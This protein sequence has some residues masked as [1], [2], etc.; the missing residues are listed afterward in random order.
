MSAL[1][2]AA[3]ALV[4]GIVPWYELLP[5]LASVL[6]VVGLAYSYLASLSS[7]ALGER[8]RLA[9]AKHL[10]CGRD[11]RTPQWGEFGLVVDVFAI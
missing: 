7:V 10:C 4:V 8:G 2:V 11:G 1:L 3:A 5:A 9:R 6:V